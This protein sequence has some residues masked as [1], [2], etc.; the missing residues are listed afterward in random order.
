MSRVTPLRAAASRTRLDR[1]VVGGL[2]HGRS[3]AS[4]PSGRRSRRGGG[5]IGR[6]GSDPLRLGRHA[7]RFARARSTRANAT[8]MAAFGLPFDEVVYRRNYVPDWRLMYRRLGVPDDR[9]DEANALWQTTSPGAERR[10]RVR[11][12]RPPHWRGCGDA[13]CRLGIVTAGHRDVVEPQLERT[14]LGALLP[15][16]V[17]GDD[18]PVHKPDPGAAPAGAPARRPWPSARTTS[19]TSATRRPTCR[20]PSR[21]ARAR[22]GSSRSLGDP[23]ELRAAG[24]DEVAPSVAAWVDGH[25]AA[26]APADARPAPA[27]GPCGRAGGARRPRRRRRAGP[28]GPRRTPG[29]A[30]PTASTSSSPPTAAPGTPRASACAIDRWVGDGDSIAAGGPRGARA[31]PASRSTARPSTRTRRTP[32]WRSRAAIDAGADGVT[33]LG[34]LGGAR[35]DHALANVW[36]LAHPAP[37]RPRRPCCSTARSR[38]RLVGAGPGCGPGARRPGRRPRLAPAVRRRRRRDP[39]RRPP[40]PAPR[41]A[42][43]PRGRSRGLS[44]VRRRAEHASVTRRDRR[45]SSSSRPLLRSRR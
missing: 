20:W 22:S 14:G 27:T 40:L 6:H 37:R 34:A 44:N 21:S 12:R 28:G 43:R 23:D 42:A 13:G 36:L 4:G 18:L 45:D 24:A 16:R 41:R 35:L 7:G 25:L 11:R 5:S 3:L 32:S 9:L 15:V 1:Q 38:I 30:G 33:I 29:R 39:D 19:P 31:R 8:V 17:F 26:D 10:R 2:G